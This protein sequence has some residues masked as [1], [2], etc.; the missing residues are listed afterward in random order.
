MDAL[1]I[2]L[3]FA[4]LIV[5]G[6][7]LVRGAVSIARRFDV[8]PM[9]IGLT[10]VGFGTSMPELVTSLQAAM[11]GSP[12][13]A[14]G[15]VVGS[16]IANILLI[17]GA[18]ALMAP[19]MVSPQAFRRDGSMLALATLLCLALVLSGT[20]G[21]LS[22]ALLL[23]CLLIYLVATLV[24]E[25]R[26][27]TAAG[28]V[29]QAEADTLESEPDTLAR[30]S[31]L[32]LLGLVATIVGAR[33]L[34]S[35][36]VAI[37]TD[38][39]VSEAVIG[40]TI[41]AIGTSMPELVTSVIAARKGQSDVAFGNV[42]GSNLFNILGILG[43]TALFTPLSVPSIIVSQDIWVMLAATVL[44]L[45]MAVT[46]WRITRREGGLLLGGYLAYLSFLLLTAI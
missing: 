29:Y 39:G 14:I 2:L 5:G 20:I 22:G 15:N 18:A 10:L 8:S 12:G 27:S 24:I 1:W 3:G 26:R 23:A 19:I 45:W 36:A 46:G 40:L 34:V 16:N 13:I 28:A 17:L 37:A 9:V 4:G 35:G 33:F 6:E 25:R 11:V 21:R 32:L 43:V 41:V 38:L 7:W 31:T 30:A 44:L 42:V